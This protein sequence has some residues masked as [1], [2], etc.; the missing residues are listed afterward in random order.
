MGATELSAVLWR[1]RQLLELLLFKL[2]EKQRILTTGRVRWLGHATREVEHVLDQI[3]ATE[4]ERA[5]EA[6]AVAGT[7][8]IEPSSNLFA[9]ATAASPPWDE[10]LTGHWE[11]FV[12]LTVEIQYL[13]EE[14]RELITNTL[15]ATS[16]A[17]S[18]ARDDGSAASYELR[19]QEIGYRAALGAM[20]RVVQP[21]L[22]AF[23]ASTAP[24]LIP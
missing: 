13:A 19:M 1:E 24:T 15:H 10:L 9:L 14:N 11:A 5:V 7:F 12:S 6:N 21:S 3:R 22:Q 2:E 8:G 17:T 18:R 23:V 16:S 4:L 20:V